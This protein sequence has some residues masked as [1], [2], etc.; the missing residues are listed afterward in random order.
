ML[1]DIIFGIGRRYV[2]WPKLEEKTCE[3]A[4]GEAP[5]RGRLGRPSLQTM[6]RKANNGCNWVRRHFWRRWII[7]N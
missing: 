5:M 1:G 7:Q 3:H 2:D 4:G 6:K